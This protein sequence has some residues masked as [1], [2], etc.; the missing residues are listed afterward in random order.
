ML[1][2]LIKNSFSPC[3][4]WKGTYLFRT[5]VSS[6]TGVY[7]VTKPN[8]K[9]CC[10]ESLAPACMLASVKKIFLSPPY[11]TYFIEQKL[12]LG[13]TSQTH[14]QNKLIS[15][16]LEVQEVQR[17]REC[18]SCI[19]VDTKMRL[20]KGETLGETITVLQYGRKLDLHLRDHIWGELF[21]T[22][23]FQNIRLGFITPLSWTH[24]G[25]GLL[26]ALQFCIFFF[27]FIEC[28]CQNSSGVKSTHVLRASSRDIY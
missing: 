28:P 4:N 21:L 3:I 7:F 11:I 22:H 27:R 26:C 1:S 16:P 9:S 24:W 12:P 23:A 20:R 6:Y 18:W 17:K 14:S 8:T 5:T 19:L 10:S 2:A 15:K 13:L 25:L